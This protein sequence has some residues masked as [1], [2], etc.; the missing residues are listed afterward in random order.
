MIASINKFKIANAMETRKIMEFWIDG[1]NK[2]YKTMNDLF[3]TGNYS[4][5]LFIGHLVIE[6]LLKALYSKSRNEAP[7]PI[8]DLRRLALNAGLKI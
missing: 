2:D 6:K 7:P 3:D 8:H 1:S 5:A 4:W